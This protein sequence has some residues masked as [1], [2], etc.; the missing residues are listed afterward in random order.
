MGTAW[1]RR[2]DEAVTGAEVVVGFEGGHQRHRRQL[3][4]VEAPTLAGD[5]LGMPGLDE[6]AHGLGAG[7]RAWRFKV[8]LGPKTTAGIRKQLLD[9]R[10]WPAARG[11]DA[12]TPP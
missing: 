10:G 5:V 4:L 8:R 3:E 1:H 6:V 9:P 2:G 11:M 7:G 12:G